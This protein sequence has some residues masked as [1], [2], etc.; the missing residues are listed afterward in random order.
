[1]AEDG[2][3]Q[4]V[5]SLDILEEIHP[6]LEYET[7]LSILKRSGKKPNSIMT[8]I[9]SL[10]SLVDVKSTASAI[11]EDPTDNHVLACAKDAAADFVI[12][13]DRHLLKLGK[14]EN[15][16]I[17]GASSLLARKDTTTK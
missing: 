16:S 7:I 8:T 10:C 4:L 17:L 12:S 6:V 9:V 5:A 14:Y 1:M 2:Q 3:V 13:G 15:I 11:Q